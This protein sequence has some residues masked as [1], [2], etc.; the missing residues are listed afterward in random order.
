[1][2]PVLSLPDR[3]RA[4]VL[5]P[6]PRAVVRRALRHALCWTLAYL[7]LAGAWVGLFGAGRPALVVST[8]GL[9]FAAAACAALH[10][11]QRASLLRRRDLQLA[12]IV[13]TASD[14]IVT[15]DA[16]QRIVVF[17]RAAAQVFR[18]PAEQALGQPLER[19]IPPP[20]Q[21]AHRAHVERFAAT[22]LATHRLGGPR[23]L[24][25]V[26]ADGEAFPMQATVSRLGEGE[27]VLMT[28]VLRDA[29]DLQ[30]AQRAREAQSAAEAASQAKTEF[31]ARMSHELRTPLNAILGFSQL[32]LTQPKPPLPEGQARQAR[33]IVEAGWH[34]LALVNDLLDVAR[35]ES[36]TLR[37]ECGRVALHGLLDEA[38]RL[39][40]KDALRQSLAF[41]PAFRAAPDADVWCDALRL[42]QV[43]L[44]LMSNAVKYNRPGG[45]VRI[46]AALEGERVR[47]RVIDT[48]IGMT[49]EQLAHLFEPFNRLGRERQG[50]DGAGIG[51][52]LS[53]Q[54]VVAMKG[55]LKVASRAGEGTSVDVVLPRA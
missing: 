27:D 39:I 50:V 25:A 18:V 45:R 26:R 1:M 21:A 16:Q 3:L 22:G 43:M 42:R 17:N 9:V 55:E 5:P 28:V 49:P 13:D 10:L 4:R 46:E 8:A 19:F 11:G 30:E 48:G 12:G 20:L 6:A 24:M 53:R 31:L 14:A 35:I 33:H 40:E 51:L 23:T 47:V 7:A 52:A 2:I 34:L 32:L 29:S 37:M 36:G 54:L 44:N 15:V 38:W 41:D